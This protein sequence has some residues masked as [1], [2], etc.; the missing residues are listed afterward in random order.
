MIH[1]SS[2]LLQFKMHIGHTF[3]YIEL[4]DSEITHLMKAAV[5]L[6][7]SK[8]IISPFISALTDRTDG[9]KADCNNV[10]Q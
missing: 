4:K 1:T 8:I 3:I 2:L 9:S 5:K 6:I 7:E 10:C